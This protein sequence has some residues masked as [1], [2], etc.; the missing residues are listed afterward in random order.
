MERKDWAHMLWKH[1]RH[2][3]YWEKDIWIF[4]IHR[5]AQFH[6]VSAVV[7]LR[8]GIV[9]VFDS[10]G[11]NRW[12]TDIEVCSHSRCVQSIVLTLHRLF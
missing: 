5:P 1:A 8:T 11:S 4:P 9:H 3:K 10:F 2:S 6:W 7:Y 12:D